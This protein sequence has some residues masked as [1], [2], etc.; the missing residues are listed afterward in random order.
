[1]VKKKQQQQPVTSP[2]SNRFR[3]LCCKTMFGMMPFII[4][5]PGTKRIA[6][7]DNHLVVNVVVIF[8]STARW[9]LT[10]LRCILQRRLCLLGFM[11]AF[12]MR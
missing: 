5:P 1:M 6:Q 8:E 9:C 3:K 2:C 12:D 10:V 4:R 11:S 7:I